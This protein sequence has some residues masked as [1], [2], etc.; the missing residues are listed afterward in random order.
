[1][2]GDKEDEAVN[3]GEWC[4]LQTERL[5]R[6]DKFVGKL[7]KEIFIAGNGEETEARGKEDLIQE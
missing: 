1:M 3:V 5:A 6:F 2:T 7:K 4:E